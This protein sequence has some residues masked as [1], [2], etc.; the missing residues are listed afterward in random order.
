MQFSKF[1]LIMKDI[2]HKKAILALIITFLYAHS[3]MALSVKHHFDVFVGIF[4][5]A[6]TDF[7][8]KISPSQYS[9]NS[10]VYT[11][12]LFDTLYPFEAQY[13]T[14][15]RIIANKMQTEN[16][17]YKSQSRFNTRTKNIIYDKNGTPIKSIS[18]KNNKKREKKIAISANNSNTTDLQSVVA[19]VVRQY[20]QNKTCHTMQKV[21]D[22]KRRYNVIFEDLG[23]EELPQTEVS[24]YFGKAI[25]CAMRI[26]RLQEKGDDALWKMTSQHPI[27]FWIMTDKD[28]GAPF[29]ARVNAGD[30]PL[31]EMIVYTTKVEVKK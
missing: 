10:N 26:D 18:T 1:F 31:G 8:Y 27:Y 5:A 4:N 21:F 25:K 17:S 20:N 22:G 19:T 16:Y 14:S 15:G 6:E 2:L 9:V 3:A 11:K 13:A 29:I 23:S 28:S 30:T 7:E 24:Q 12:G